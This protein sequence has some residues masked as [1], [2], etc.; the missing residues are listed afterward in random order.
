MPNLRK[1]FT[2]HLN[3]YVTTAKNCRNYQLASFL[4]DIFSTI[5]C[6]TRC[7]NYK[8][9]MWKDCERIPSWSILRYHQM[10]CLKDMTQRKLRQDKHTP[11]LILQLGVLDMKPSPDNSTSV[12][13]QDQWDGNNGSVWTCHMWTHGG[14]VPHSQEP[15]TCPY[16]EPDQSSLCIPI[17]LPEGQF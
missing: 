15:A 3:R 8:C 16:P 6:S 14:S 17:P 1:N 12:F 7:Y 10:F 11:L 2:L 4:N 5:L 13:I 9:M